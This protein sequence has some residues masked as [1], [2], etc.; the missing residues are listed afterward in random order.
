M[1]REFLGQPI[2]AQKQ[3]VSGLGIEVSNIDLG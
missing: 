3:T 1:V 2:A